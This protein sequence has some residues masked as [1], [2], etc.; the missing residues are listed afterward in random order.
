MP[1]KSKEMAD[2]MREMTRAPTPGRARSRPT[3]RPLSVHHSRHNLKHRFELVKTLGEGTYG[4]VKLG[5]ERNTGEQVAIKYIKKTK[6]H[7]E[8]DL[9][10]IRREIGILSSLKHPHIVNI[11]GVFEKKDKIVMVMDC[12]LGGELYDY[13]NERR[14]LTEKDARRIFRQIVSAIYYCHQN[15][16]VHRDLKLENIILDEQSNVKIADFGLANNFGHNEL[17]STFCGSP[18]YASPEIVNGQPYHGPEVDMWSLGVVLYT[19]VYGAM[20]F[21]NAN[22]KVLRKQISSGEYYEPS[23]QSEAGGLIRQLLSVNPAKR[24]TMEEVLGHWWINEGYSHTPNLEPYPRIAVPPSKSLPPHHSYSSDSESEYETRYKSGSSKGI[25]KKTVES[26]FD[27]DEALFD[28]VS[29][30]TSPDACDKN[31]APSSSVNIEP[32]DQPSIA[33]RE[34]CGTLDNNSGDESKKVFDSERKP[35]RGILKRRGKFSGGDSGCD[36]RD[37]LARKM[38]DEESPKRASDCE[39]LS[40]EDCDIN[41]DLSKTSSST[42]NLGSC[43]VME[44]CVVHTLPSH[45][46]TDVVQSGNVT[47]SISICISSDRENFSNNPQ[48]VC[49]CS[50]T[51]VVRRRK[52]ILKKGGSTMEDPRNR[53][54]VGSLSSNSSADI[55]DLSFDSADGEQFI[56]KYDRQSLKRESQNISPLATEGPR[57]EAF[58]LSDDFSA[59]NLEGGSQPQTK[60]LYDDRMFDIEEARQVY[61]QALDIC[62]RV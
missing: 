31:S 26:S 45:K 59:L 7:D 53:L 29:S 25:L 30:K 57:F 32:D 62:H 41:I 21:E 1:S 24:A 28:I 18:L 19:L 9:N 3:G 38:E 33:S 39:D 37:D 16:V 5:I 51:K 42:P 20:P 12:A 6:I 50:T 60:A 27:E 2:T 14:R 4:K 22:L 35:R 23:H 13:I 36:M 55:L 47:S 11:R 8:T 43:D 48:T 61:R 10:R 46:E 52:G 49:T 56:G 34:L 44:E 58:P 40:Y 17:L 54:S 15:G